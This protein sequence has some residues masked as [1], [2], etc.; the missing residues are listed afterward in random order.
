MKARARTLWPILVLALAF[1]GCGHNPAPAN[2]GEEATTHIRVENQNFLDMDIY[3]VPTSGAQ[4]RL[5]TVT[6]KSTATFVIPS[7]LMFGVSSLRFLADPVGSN[8]RGISQEIN[9]TAGDTVV[10]IIPAT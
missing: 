10:M 1:A 7:R 3:V 8:A 2:G 5:G 9:V 4:Q 6:G